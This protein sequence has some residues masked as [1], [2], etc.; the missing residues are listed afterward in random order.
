[1][2]LQMSNSECE[3]GA[4]NP[5]FTPPF[6]VEYVSFNARHACWISPLPR[7]FPPLFFK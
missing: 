5:H 1:M 4:L 3:I 2:I 7:I 6:L